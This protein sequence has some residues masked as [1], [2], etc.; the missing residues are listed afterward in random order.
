MAEKQEMT[1]KRTMTENMGKYTGSGQRYGK[2]KRMANLELLRCIAM[3]MVTVLH[4]LEKGGLL[5]DLT[6][7]RLGYAG[8]T[9]WLLECF[10]IV[11]VNVYMLISGYFL[12]QSSFKLSRLIQLWLQVWVYSMGFGLLGALSGV[13]QGQDFDIH[14]LLTL[15]FPFSMGHY[16]FMTAYLFLYLLL[17]L[18]G[19]AAGR[20]TKRQLQVV[21][22]LLF[23]TFC[24]VKSI[25]PVRLEMDQQGYDY[26]WYLCVF[27]AAVYLRRFGISFLD[28]KR[29]CLGL[30]VGSCLLIF[31]GTMGLRQV[32]L[33]TGSLERMLTLFLNYNHI[34]PFL[35]AAGLFGFFRRIRAE[36]RAAA[37]ISRMA[38]YTLGV[39]LLQENLG[40]RYTWQN[41]LGAEKATGTDSLG[42]VGMLL[43]WTAAAAAVVFLCGILVDVV[44][45]RVFDL[46]HGALCRWSFYHGLVKR[47]EAVDEVFRPG[48]SN[49]EEKD[50]LSQGEGNRF[51]GSPEQKQETNLTAPAKASQESKRS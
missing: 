44:R 9:A 6:G 40:F 19:T 8:T 20:V 48:A 41:W 7:E 23:F 1:E 10:C 33:H 11:A 30:Y 5:P 14:Y 35:A 32:Y 28:R 47:I 18:V 26:L 50:D 3:L 31:A 27:L 42:A 43:L 46:L 21:L 15:V 13:M 29:N 38:P 12:V 51:A 24:F 45:K 2:G 49:Q 22:G 39:Y 25:L 34:L 16:W 4:Y 17:P 37:W 36:G